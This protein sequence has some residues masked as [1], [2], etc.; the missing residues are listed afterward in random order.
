MISI[1]IEVNTDTILLIYYCLCIPL[2]LDWEVWFVCPDNEQDQQTELF[3]ATPVLCK[4]ILFCI[5]CDFP[6]F[7]EVFP[8]LSQKSLTSQVCPKPEYVNPVTFGKS[9]DSEIGFF[10]YK[11]CKFFFKYHWFYLDQ[12]F[13]FCLNWL[14]IVL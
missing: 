6:I 12:L 3:M 7:T 4:R 2:A 1:L 9:P 14:W 13:R 10:L 11:C 5:T 8:S